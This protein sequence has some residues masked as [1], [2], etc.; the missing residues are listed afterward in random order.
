MVNNRSK[1]PALLRFLGNI[2]LLIIPR[3]SPECARTAQFF[4]KIIGLKYNQSDGPE[5]T[6]ELEVRMAKKGKGKKK[7][8][9]QTKKGKG[10]KKK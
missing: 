7:D 3:N 9:K 6:M 1:L 4:R 10:K 8:K 5:W 2:R